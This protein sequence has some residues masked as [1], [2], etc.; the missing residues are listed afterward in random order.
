MNIPRLLFAELLVCSTLI[1]LSPAAARISKTDL[2]GKGIKGPSSL[3]HVLIVLL[4]AHKMALVQ[5]DM[6]HLKF[7][8]AFFQIH[9]HILGFSADTF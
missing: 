6:F 9:P 5:I 1:S 8:Q 4:S 7:G 3:Y 2:D